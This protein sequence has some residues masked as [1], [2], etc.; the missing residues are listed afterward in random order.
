ML[1]HPGLSASACTQEHLRL[2]AGADT[3]VHALARGTFTVYCS[4]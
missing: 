4:A 2:L 1:A 3:Y